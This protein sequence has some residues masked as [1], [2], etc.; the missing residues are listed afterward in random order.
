MV[1]VLSFALGSQ[2]IFHGQLV[3]APWSEKA[4]LLDD[5][6]LNSEGPVDDLG[7]GVGDVKLPGG[8]KT[9]VVVLSN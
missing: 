2:F 6:S 8:C 1:F 9:G 5:S 4:F 3:L 7:V